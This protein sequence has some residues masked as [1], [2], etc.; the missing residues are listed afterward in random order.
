[1]IKI[2]SKIYLEH[3]SFESCSPLCNRTTKHSRLKQPT[4]L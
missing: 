1:M 2:S 3:S 4:P